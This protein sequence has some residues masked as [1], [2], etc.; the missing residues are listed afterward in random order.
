MKQTALAH[1]DQAI[2]MT[3]SGVSVRP[4]GA[5]AVL[6][7]IR[8][9]LLWIGATTFGA[10]ALAV[11]AL[12]VMQ[13]RYQSQAL[14]VVSKPQAPRPVDGTIAAPNA[15][16]V[17]D[18]VI[19]SLLDEMTA[20]PL[21]RKVIADLDLESDPEFNPRAARANSPP[22]SLMAVIDETVAPAWQRILA[23][24]NPRAGDS[25]DLEVL[26]N[27]TRAISVS[28]KLAS[29][30]VVVSAFSTDPEKAAAMANALTTSYLKSRLEKQKVQ[31]AQ[32]EQWLGR[33]ACRAPSRMSGSM[34]RPPSRF[35][36]RL[37]TI[38]ARHRASWRSNCP[39]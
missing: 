38:K 2:G 31:T 33:Q 26:D 25:S 21:L 32:L 9:N 27:V 23:F 12:L 19:S 5:A 15:T 29:H 18:Q 17:S 22:S 28:A 10:L 1:S 30:T 34:K 3:D 39:S 35:A 37:G 24:L 4:I 36:R 13:P 11:A 16:T 8:Q 20:A 14:L 7:V 6:A